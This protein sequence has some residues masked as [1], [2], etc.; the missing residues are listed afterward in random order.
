MFSFWFRCS[1]MIVLACSLY[2]SLVCFAISWPVTFP[3]VTLIAIL[4][5][6]IIWLIAAFCVM[7]SAWACR[8]FLH[9]LT[10]SGAFSDD[11][12]CNSG[13]LTETDEFWWSVLSIQ[14][15]L[16]GTRWSFLIR[17]RDS[18]VFSDD[19]VGF[20]TI[21]GVLVYLFASTGNGG[22]TGKLLLLLR[23]CWYWSWWDCWKYPWSSGG[24]WNFYL[25]QLG[26]IGCFFST[27]VVCLSLINPHLGLFVFLFCTYSLN[28]CLSYLVVF[29]Q[30]FYWHI[31]ALELFQTET[32]TT[33]LST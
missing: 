19:A 33:V 16:A 20:F 15:G 23:L 9:R 18:E 8:S 31:S 1:S 25:R 26:F 28:C 32:I 30:L 22:T 13:R 2:E 5:F 6:S 17:F 12:W 24:C 11:V 3:I 27:L 10:K 7:G 21:T 4:W 14:S 29:Q